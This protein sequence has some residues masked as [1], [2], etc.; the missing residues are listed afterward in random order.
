MQIASVPGHQGLLRLHRHQPSY[1]G[2]FCPQLENINMSGLSAVTDNGFL[3][4]MKSS[5]SG[6]VDIDLNNCENLT[7]ANNMQRTLSHLKYINRNLRTEG[8]LT[9]NGLA[10]DV[11][12][13][14]GMYKEPM[15]THPKLLMLPTAHP[16]NPF[17]LGD[18]SQQAAKVELGRLQ[19][20]RGPD[21]DSEVIL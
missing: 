12:T 19:L 9:M 15:S 1:V 7:D 14:N 11:P 18:R 5:D 17:Q 21:E 6:L 3:P 20:Q 10:K 13:V 2:M 4:L 8:V 16:K